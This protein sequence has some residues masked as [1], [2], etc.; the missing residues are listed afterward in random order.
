MYFL[1]TYMC[2]YIS[3]VFYDSLTIYLFDQ[4]KNIQCVR[5]S[6]VLL[7]YL[8]YTTPSVATY[9]KYEQYS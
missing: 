6:Y 3:A 4:I 9:I 1:Y 8:F 2:T 7:Q 5:I